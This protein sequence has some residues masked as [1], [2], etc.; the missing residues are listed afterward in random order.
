MLFSFS[1]PRAVRYFPISVTQGIHSSTQ[2]W[3]L[4]SVLSEDVFSHCAPSLSLFTVLS[5]EALLTECLKPVAGGD[6]E[7]ANTDNSVVEE[8]RS[9]SFSL[10]YSVH[11]EMELCTSIS[12]DSNATDNCN[13]K[14]KKGGVKGAGKTVPIFNMN[15]CSI[16]LYIWTNFWSNEKKPV[17]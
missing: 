9:D 1:S 7:R 13:A 3:Q 14:A 10:C 15:F 5:W 16:K 17:T 12:E 4:S 8:W 11:G 2:P 6:T